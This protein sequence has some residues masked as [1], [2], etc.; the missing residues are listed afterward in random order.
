MSHCEVNSEIKVSSLLTLH[1]EFIGDLKTRSQQVHGVSC[2]VTEG[3]QQARSVSSSCEFAVR[4]MSGSKISL[5][6]VG[7]GLKFFTWYIQDLIYVFGMSE[8]AHF[9]LR[10]LFAK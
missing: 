5:L 10:V 3:S 6:C 4:Q 7:S 2:K 9:S 1:G 8:Q